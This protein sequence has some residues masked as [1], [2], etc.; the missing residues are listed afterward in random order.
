MTKKYLFNK[1]VILGG[2]KGIGRAIYLDLKK[3][4]IR[5]IVS[6][7]SKD[8]DTS[9]IKSVQSFAKKHPIVDIIVLNTGGPPNI[10]F[11]KI[12]SELWIKYFH[13]LFL[14]Y[15][16]LLK[17]IKINKGGYIFNISTALIKEPSS[18]LI[19]S[20]SLRVAFASLLKSLTHKYNKDNVSIISIAPGPFKTNRIKKL[21]SN[22]KKF[23]RDLPLKKIG[24]P[25]EIGA[26][27]KFIL[28]N[29]IKYITGTTIFFDGS[30]NKTFI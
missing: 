22:I 9:N 2:S 13:Q 11:E 18:N 8:I 17:K 20:T 7:S 21:V 27:V 25:K 4:K 15:V 5:T 16:T 19:I 14:G 24:D 6:C 10:D 3:L 28:F 29:K 30:T 12:T 26:F 1:A 23:E